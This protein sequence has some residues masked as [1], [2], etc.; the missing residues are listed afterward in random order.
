MGARYHGGSAAR[1]RALH[2][3]YATARTVRDCVRPGRELVVTATGLRA[4][5]RAGSGDASRQPCL[6]ARGAWYRRPCG[7]PRP[8]RSMACD[9][10][11]SAETNRCSHCAQGVRCAALGLWVRAKCRDKPLCPL[12]ARHAIRPHWAC[13]CAPTA[14]IN[15][16]ARCA[17][18][19]CGCM[20][21]AVARRWRGQA[22]A[23]TA[24]GRRFGQIGGAVPP[25]ERG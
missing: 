17:T 22:A 9:C 8:S 21:R 24:A 11:P 15:R 3:L 12:R 1:S 23:P 20:R 14:E 6:C 13:G 4:Q 5:G 18:R 25:R 10:A 16:C 19:G 2:G 7:P